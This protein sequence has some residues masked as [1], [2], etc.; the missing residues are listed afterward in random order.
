[1]QKPSL[2]RVISKSRGFFSKLEPTIRRELIRQSF[3][4]T[5]DHGETA[6]LIEGDIELASMGLFGGHPSRGGGN[7]T[8]ISGRGV[9]QE[10]HDHS[11]R[12]LTAVGLQ[13]WPHRQWR[14]EGKRGG[15]T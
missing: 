2:E 3:N 10:V 5:I 6:S 4:G 8:R 15:V 11:Q 12:R 13:L 1:M 7:S 9:R 14:K